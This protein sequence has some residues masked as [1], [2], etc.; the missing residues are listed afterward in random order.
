MGISTAQGRINVAVFLLAAVVQQWPRHATP[1]Q[2]IIDA[3][4]GIN[5]CT[6]EVRSMGIDYGFL[7]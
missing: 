5:T 6:Y 7:R 2:S 3:D 4:D 1:Q